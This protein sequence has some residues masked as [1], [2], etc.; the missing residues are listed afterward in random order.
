MP[1]S[2]SDEVIEQIRVRADIVEVISEH[3]SLTKKGK[4]YLGKCPFHSEKTPSFSV[5]Q[6]KQMYYCFGCG[7]GGDLINFVMNKE[8][9]NFPEA[10]EKIAKR[11]NIE[12]PREGLSSEQKEQIKKKQRIIDANDLAAKY[13]N[14]LIKQPAGRQASEYLDSRNITDIKL[15]D[16][17]QLGFAP[18]SW[19]NFIKL[20]YSRGFTQ[21]EL[22]EAGLVVKREKGEGV[23]DRFRNRLM[24]T[25]F[26]AGGQP[27]GFG[28]RVLDQSLP[29]YLNTS[30]TLVF[31]KTNNL[32]GLNWAASAIRQ[33]GHVIVMEGY[34]DAIAAYQHGIENVVA[35][36]GTA[37]TREQAII[38]K[39]YNNNII[40]CYDSDS[41]GE[42]AT[43]RGLEI[44]RDEKCRVKVITL[45]KGY[46]P[47]DYIRKE[48]K[49]AF[50]NLIKSA[51]SLINYKLD[52]AIEKADKNAI[53]WKA[54]VFN[55]IKADLIR[56]ENA[57][58]REEYLKLIASQLS[59]TEESLRIE[60]AKIKP[61]NRKNGIFMDKS[62]KKR[63]TING[64]ESLINKSSSAH[65]QA[66]KQ[67]FFL[68]VTDGHVRK[69]VIEKLG[70]NFFKDA[71]LCRL[72]MT[73]NERWQIGEEVSPEWLISNSQEQKE[74][75]YLAK[76][77]NKPEL[78]DKI[79][80]KMLDDCIDVLIHRN[81][82]QKINELRLQL[83]E[84]EDKQDVDKI[85]K[86]LT[87]IQRLMK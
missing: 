60:M 73:A 40:I 80:E 22:V 83:K 75:E 58:E 34:M 3:V 12:L 27:V 20:A 21:E 1:R 65:Q 13:F 33:Q 50:L 61:D 62:H 66:E 10:V 71:L 41:A 70:D 29:K 28:G 47:D 8:N 55:Y 63:N 82:Q 74:Q 31:S 79:K 69:K 57:I 43:L 19:D 4:N 14:Y 15:I 24:F 35:T 59:V 11:Y 86:L 72:Y 84:A 54:K 6:D 42:K 23:Y 87:Q 45:P 51:K 67:L 48:G 5:N 78:E 26:D 36:L 81:K 44:L 49:E 39:R 37:F 53:D 25:I 68:M 32:Y 17:L 77:F 9:L 2:I 52:L 85:K 76:I 64:S 18:N 46:D 56:T 7:A 16:K 30:D 38:L